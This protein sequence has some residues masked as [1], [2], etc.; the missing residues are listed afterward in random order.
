MPQFYKSLEDIGG[1]LARLQSAI[2]SDEVLSRLTKVWLSFGNTGRAV[3]DH[4]VII[5]LV[6]LTMRLG[7]AAAATTRL[8][9]FV[10][11]PV[12]RCDAIIPILGVSVRSDVRL[13]DDLYLM[14][15]S[16]VPTSWQR[17]SFDEGGDQA[18]QLMA[19]VNPPTAALRIEFTESKV[20]FTAA[21][22]AQ[23]L[24]ALDPSR[25]ELVQYYTDLVP[26]CLSLVANVPC[27]ALGYWFW[28]TNDVVAEFGPTGTIRSSFS[29][30]MSLLGACLNP[31]AV[32][33]I[34][35]TS[36]VSG[37]DRIPQKDQDVMRIVVDRLSTS[38][39]RIGLADKCIDLGI[40]I[41]A[42][43]LHENT[44]AAD[45]GELRFRIA[46]RGAAYAGKSPEDR[47]ATFARLREAYDLRSAAV[48]VGRVSEQLKGGR[49]T[50]EVVDETTQL[51][52]AIAEQIIGDGHFPDWD[53]LVIGGVSTLTS[54]TIEAPVVG[55]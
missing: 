27:V 14:P 50:R 9:E 52:S 25:T 41:E 8:R 4:M 7:S 43:M 5:V 17:E 37:F 13:T 44:Q 34:R 33:P 46:V 20:L 24:G 54:P 6:N 53:A 23:T 45:R 19:H 2:I 49:N 3:Q 11:H 1:P 26:A 55:K 31:V 40:A 35:A 29:S 38:R 32:D 15:W 28:P 21:E 16:T 51:V 36:V 10:D 18:R 42:M 47:K 48:H 39:R 30:D 12:T 22:R